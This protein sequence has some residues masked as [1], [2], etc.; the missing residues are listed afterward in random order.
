MKAQVLIVLGNA[1]LEGSPEDS[2]IREVSAPI[3]ANPGGPSHVPE[4][5]GL[6]CV[7]LEWV[8]VGQEGSDPIVDARD[9]PQTFGLF[10]G[11]VGRSGT[12]PF[13]RAEGHGQAGEAWKSGPRWK[14][15]VGSLDRGR[16]D[17]NPCAHGQKGHAPMKGPKLPIP[18]TGPFGK[19]TQH[20]ALTEDLLGKGQG[21]PVPFSPGDGESPER[22]EKSGQKGIREEFGLGGKARLPGNGVSQEGNVEKGEVVGRHDHPSGGGKVLEAREGHGKVGVEDDSG[23]DPE[24]PVKGGRPDRPG[25]RNYR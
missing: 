10:F 8:C 7:G 12:G 17:R 20:S 2:G 11:G 1:P 4:R 13:G 18:G 16:D 9:E 5:F 21:L 6:S 15:F 25:R 23:Q 22:E 3:R 19:K 14:A 24:N